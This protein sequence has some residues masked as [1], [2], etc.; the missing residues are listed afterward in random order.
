MRNWHTIAAALVAVFAVVQAAP[1]ARA[2]WL[3]ALS[4]GA[5]K[6]A[7][8][9]DGEL[10]AI[11]RA[12]GHLAELPAGSRSALAA[13]ATPEGHWQFVNREGQVFTAGTADEM[14]RVLP[15][16]S[17]G[18]TSEGKL[19]LY[20]SE[21]SVFANRHALEKLPKDAD[22]H[23]VTDAG[24][25]PLSRGA[26]D[27][28]I[29]KVKPNVSITLAD[30]GLFEE[31]LSYLTRPLNK[32]DIRTI[33]LEPGAANRLASAPKLDAASRAP[34]VD[35][36]DPVHLAEAFSAIRGQTALMVARFDNGK[37]FFQ[38][39][40]GGE[41]VRDLDE[42]LSAAS[43]NDVNLILLHADVPRQ[44]GGTNW[45]W[46]KIEVGGLD[47][48]MSKATFGDFLDALGARRGPLSVEATREGLGRVRIAASPSETGGAV[49][50]AQHTLDDI[51]GHVTG[52]I[53]SQALEVH[54]RDSSSQLELDGRWIPG[55]PTYVQIPYFG[56][57]A[58]GVLGWAVSRSWWRRVWP[59]RVRG[60]R[61][62]RIGHWLKSLPNFAA[63]LLLFLPVAG[64]PAFVWQIML[65]VWA[66]IT[67]PF[68]WIAKLFRRRVEV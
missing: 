68:R 57:I 54:A 8:Y 9:A 35:Q 22:L 33:A 15:A 32:S 29:A 36:L 30:R 60:E 14:K 44:P 61:E 46:Q 53:A 48:A 45:L 58:A 41:I 28:L 37:V 63:F 67:A 42:V 56:G 34:L 18:A 19:T 7:K 16:L 65:Q 1:E 59:P 55:I 38:P 17:P 11:G 13:H 47:T 25:F 27:V 43:K 26:G 21:D 20:L 6:A 52:E 12:A 62:G 2:N 5:G 3:T 40:K 64:G 23:L 50:G 66:T 49:A 10:G 51:I 4:K 31:S 39:A 24:A